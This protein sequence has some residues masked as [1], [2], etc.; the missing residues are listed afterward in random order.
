MQN[1]QQI[2]DLIKALEGEDEQAVLNSVSVL[3]GLNLWNDFVINAYLKLLNHQNAQIRYIVAYALAK[4]SNPL[5]LNTFLKI[6]DD[7]KDVRLQMY[8]A[9]ALG[10]IGDKK[11]VEPIINFLRRQS[12]ENRKTDEAIN[13]PTF[14]NLIAEEEA[15]FKPGA[16][17]CAVTALGQLED[18]RAVEILLKAL[19]DEASEVRIQAIWA[20]EH[21]EDERILPALEWIAKNDKGYFHVT[22]LDQVAMKAIKR[23]NK[24]L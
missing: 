9:M 11:A 8:A 22:R 3:S 19:R 5:T 15:K 17:A 24:P 20:L 21:F 12:E 6:L 16:R 18:N 10:N 2:A 23:I 7:D 1:Y 13:N 4:I 14:I